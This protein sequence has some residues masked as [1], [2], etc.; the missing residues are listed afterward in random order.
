MDAGT[1]NNIAWVWA[2]PKGDLLLDARQFLV[3]AQTFFGVEQRCLKGLVGQAIR[4]KSGGSRYD[5]LTT[6]DACDEN[7]VKTTLPGSGWTYHHDGINIHIN[8][9]ARHEDMS[10][11]TE[12]EDAYMRKL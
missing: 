12:I 1:Q 8:K 5:R 4:Q 7:L 11:D 2:F 9:I 3:V 10:I 6:F